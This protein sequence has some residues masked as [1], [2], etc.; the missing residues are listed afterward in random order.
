MTTLAQATHLGGGRGLDRAFALAIHPISGEVFVAGET[1]STDFPGTAGGAQPTFGGGL[2]PG[3][4]FVA[5]L[6]AALT[7]LAQA[8]YLGGSLSDA[9]FALGACPSN[10]KNRN[11]GGSETPRHVAIG[12]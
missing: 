11:L 9:A 7:T 8:T 3:D 4:A 12:P 5:R 1:G 2:L 6:N 10:A